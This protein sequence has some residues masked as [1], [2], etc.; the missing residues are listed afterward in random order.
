MCKSERGENGAV[1]ILALIFVIV[2]GVVGVALASLTSTNLSAT[3]GLQAKRGAEFAADAAVDAA[4]Q[5]VRYSGATFTSGT[6]APCA[7]NTQPLTMDGSTIWVECTLGTA[8]APTGGRAVEFQ[9]CGVDPVPTCTAV[10][11]TAQVAF[12]DN[13]VGGGPQVGTSVTIVSW[14]D[15][16]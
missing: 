6:W 12:D 10:D 1:L 14:N 9:A 4:V 16:A 7:P 8:T 15:S 5:I 3:S 2:T 13:A 11:L